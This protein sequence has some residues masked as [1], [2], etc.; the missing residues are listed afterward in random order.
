MSTGQ[1]KSPGQAGGLWGGRI[2]CHGS[3]QSRGGSRCDLGPCE[4]GHRQ[5]FSLESGH[6]PGE[7]STLGPSAFQGMTPAPLTQ[8]RLGC[9]YDDMSMPVA[10]LPALTFRVGPDASLLNMLPGLFSGLW[11][12]GLAGAT[13]QLSP[14]P[15]ES[16]GACLT[17]RFLGMGRCLAADKRC[18]RALC[19]QGSALMGLSA[20][21]CN[22]C[23]E[24]A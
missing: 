21:S 14:A 6:G 11:Q 13:P 19:A 1:S 5:T 12:G 15:L 4:E 17:F 2:V 10:H 8:N 9:L 20:S 18:L 24:S 22:P 3:G 7:L 23:L 16:R